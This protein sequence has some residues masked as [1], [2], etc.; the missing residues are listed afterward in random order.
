[1]TAAT[2]SGR[3]GIRDATAPGRGRGARD[4]AGRPPGEE[5]DEA[6]PANASSKLTGEERN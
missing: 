6:I 5:D 4:L 1:M 2:S 3:P